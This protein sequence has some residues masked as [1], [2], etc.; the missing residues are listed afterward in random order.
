MR[1]SKLE[2]LILFFNIIVPTYIT[3]IIRVLKN[4]L[5]CNS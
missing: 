2:T 3:F 4:Y 5:I 1:I